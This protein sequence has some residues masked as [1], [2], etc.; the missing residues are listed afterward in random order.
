MKNPSVSHRGKTKTQH[1]KRHINQKN[2]QT[3][4]QTN[5]YTEWTNIQGNKG[6]TTNNIEGNPHKDNSWSYNRNSSA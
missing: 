4:K 3:N 2:K 1:V 6:I 5:K